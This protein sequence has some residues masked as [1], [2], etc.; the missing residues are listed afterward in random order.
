MTEKSKHASFAPTIIAKSFLATILVAVLLAAFLPNSAGLLIPAITPLMEGALV[1]WGKAQAGAVSSTSGI[2]ASAVVPIMQFVVKYE[3]AFMGAG[4]HLVV[5]YGLILREI[6]SGAFYS[7]KLY[8]IAQKDNLSEVDIQVAKAYYVKSEEVGNLTVFVGLLFGI[9]TLMS[10]LFR[11][12]VGQDLGID[13]KITAGSILGVI[14][15]FRY[16]VLIEFPTFIL[17]GSIVTFVN[18]KL[19]TVN[20]N[21]ISPVRRLFYAIVWRLEHQEAGDVEN[22]AQLKASA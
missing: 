1:L 14:F 13:W 17:P 10:F 5:L 2:Y 18:T 16:H 11:P 15:C 12:L 9:A 6:F 4:W 19:N 21:I 8:R 22:A 3:R 7:T 20:P